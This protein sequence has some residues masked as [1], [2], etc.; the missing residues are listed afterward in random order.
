MS[1]L[2]L[3]LLAVTACRNTSSVP[4]RSAPAPTSVTTVSIAGSA[5][6]NYD[7]R[8]ID[9]SSQRV[10]APVIG[11][12]A[13]DKM[14]YVTVVSFDVD[15]SEQLNL[16]LTIAEL[17]RMKEMTQRAMCGAG[18]PRFALCSRTI[19]RGDARYAEAVAEYL[20]LYHHVEVKP[21]QSRAV[22]T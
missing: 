12:L 7:V 6:A 10:L 13:I 9:E 20:Q 4:A 3:I 18:A 15:Q 22:G 17:N 11:V 1:R 14:G 21:Q 8:R 5:T 19:E 2:T 16:P